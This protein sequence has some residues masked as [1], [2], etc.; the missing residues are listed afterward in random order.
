MSSKELRGLWQFALDQIEVEMP[1]TPTD[2]K[3]N[4]IICVYE[5]TV[6]ESE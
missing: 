2:M 5:Q 3:L 6:Q 1:T 4:K